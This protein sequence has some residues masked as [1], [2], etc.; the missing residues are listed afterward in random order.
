MK[1]VRDFNNIHSGKKTETVN[2]QQLKEQYK[3]FSTVVQHMARDSVQH[4]GKHAVHVGS[5]TT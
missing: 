4:L 1:N 3:N 5:R 2:E